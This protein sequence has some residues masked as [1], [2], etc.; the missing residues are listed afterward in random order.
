M[1]LQFPQYRHTSGPA[2]QSIPDFEQHPVAIFPPLMI[3]EPEF[4]NAESLKKLCALLIV[5][6]LLRQTMLETVEFDGQFRGRTINIKKVNPNWMLAP[7]FESGE[8]PGPEHAPK[9]FFFLGL[10]SAQ[11]AGL[12]D[13]AHD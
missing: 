8:P 1:V 9:F 13:R 5:P 11:A 12:G 6:L 2:T 3:P 4:L 10:L 7:E